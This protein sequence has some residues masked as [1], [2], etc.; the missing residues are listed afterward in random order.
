MAAQVSMRY[1]CNPHQ[2][3][4]RSYR[5]DGGELPLQVLNGGPSYIN[6]LDALNAWQLVRELKGA[7]GLPAAAS[8]KHVSPA[9]AAV[10]VPLSDD[11]R[12]A[13]LL[14]KRKLSPLATAYARA[15]GGDCLASYGDWIALS[16]RVDTATARLIRAEA[17]DGVIA[18]GYEP[19]ALELLKSKRGG[20]Y[21][22]FRIDADYEP[23]ALEQR[24]VFGLTLEQPRNDF[25]PGADYLDQV[26]TRRRDLD[27]AARRDLVVASLAVKYTQSNSICLALDGQV[28]GTGAGQQSRV[29]CVRL[30][31]GKADLWH[32]RRHPKVLGLEFRPGLKRT[33]IHNAVDLYLQEEATTAELDVWKGNFDQVP[34]PLSAAEKRDWLDQLKGVALSSDAYL[35]FR[36]NI[37]R[38]ARSGV[39]YVVQTGGSARDEEVVQAADEC[40]MFMAFSGVRLFHH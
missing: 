33:Q 4:A 5:A 35:P 25:V 16:D 27:E 39:E 20:S 9:G 40:A 11:L 10:A 7:L 34:E 22:V 17:S 6:L 28:V 3:P 23:E 1:G 12:A 30:A 15:R 14:G 38:A 21:R 29:H 18:P 31:A 36:D 19:E 26:V 13:Y 32:L 24:Q 37:D 2:A 8:F